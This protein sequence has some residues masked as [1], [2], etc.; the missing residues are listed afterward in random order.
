MAHHHTRHERYGNPDDFR[1]YLEK[2]EGPDRA[3]WQ[4]PDQVI[5]ALKLA[6]D[7]TVCDIG[8]GPGYFSLRLA[9]TVRRVFAVEAE[10][11]MAAI[12]RDRVEAAGVR[13]VTPVVALGGDPL[14]PDASCDLALIVDTFHHFP[15]GAAYLQTLARALRPGGALVNIDFHQGELPIG[16]SPE[17]K[18]SRDDFLRLATQAGFRLQSEET[19]L[20]WQYFLRLAR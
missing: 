18:I 10:P 11:R 19:F 3:T 9:R 1:E 12:L 2:L 20:P 7:A 4:K 14:L 8:A 16:P 6:P 13:N 15:D 5:S 17:H